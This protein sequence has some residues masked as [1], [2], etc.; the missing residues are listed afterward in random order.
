ME[1][2][3]E[4]SK[5]WIKESDLTSTQINPKVTL[6]TTGEQNYVLKQ[7]GDL[8]QIIAE[9]KL[10]TILPKYNIKV[11]QPLKTFEGEYFISYEDTYYCM[12]EY[13]TGSAPGV[14]DIDQL[15]V[16]AN[17]IGKEIA[18][19]HQGLSKLHTEVQFIER[20]LYMDIYK[21]AI[22]TIEKN[23]IANSNSKVI[24]LMK[25]LKSNMEKI[26]PSLPK[27][28]IHRDTHLSNLIFEKN[29]FT[30]FLDFEIAEVNIKIFDI[31]YCLTSI[32]SELF[33]DEKLKSQW[34]SLIKPIIEGYNNQNPLT[35]EER[36][37]LWHVM[38]GIQV[39]FM[40]YFI[41]SPELLKI[42]QD[43]F[44]WIYENKKIIEE[45]VWA[46]SIG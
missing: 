24:Q 38:L 36:S 6:I 31:C 19:L 17:D 7:K 29:S 40:T 44:L 27:Q 26:L 1:Q 35:Q 30:G 43:M 42:N 11:Q 21:W 5:F 33:T 46:V 16:L 3:L 2:V 12:Y 37:A 39:I 10:L 4:I 13:L 8:D 28:I 22:P 32:L 15:K 23:Q 41:S 9:V 34:F 18:K 20:N 45:C 14:K 25:Q